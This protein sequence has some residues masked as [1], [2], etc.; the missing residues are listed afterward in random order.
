MTAN[1]IREAYNKRSLLLFFNNVSDSDN[2]AE[3]EVTADQA[4]KTLYEMPDG[5]NDFGD[6]VPAES[7]QDFTVDEMWVAIESVAD[8]FINFDPEAS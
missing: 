3:H 4:L 1:E 6:L 5:S 2:P 7:Y 8:L